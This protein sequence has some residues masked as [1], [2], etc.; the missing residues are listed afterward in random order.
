MR[1]ILMVVMLMMGLPAWA[2]E[3]DEAEVAEA[4]MPAALAGVPDA[5]AKRL[6]R[7]PDDFVEDAA[8]LIL[9]YGRDGG[10]DR[11]G[12]GQFVAVERAR[13]R[14]GALRRMWEADLDADGSV[15]TVELGVLVAAAEARYRGRMLL[16]HEAA[17]A[18]ADGTVTAVEMLAKAN[19]MALDMFSAAD[20]ERVMA[21]LSLD[22]NGDG[23]LTLDEVREVARMM[24]ET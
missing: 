16:T 3:A 11:D 15:T 7:A 23:S 20:E 18:D 5:M 1:W 12:I 14:A 4:P 13:A 19:V 9:G 10:I 24:G 6:R 8:S 2:Q 22:L 21:M 17:D